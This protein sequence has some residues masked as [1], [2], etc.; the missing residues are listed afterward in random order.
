MQGLDLNQ[1]PSGYEPEA[2]IALPFPI[3]P[4]GM[5]ARNFQ[6]CLLSTGYLA[7]MLWIVLLAVLFVFH[8]PK[9]WGELVSRVGFMAGLALISPSWATGG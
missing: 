4:V 8:R 1:R 7:L 5:N 6:R 9:N 3:V 2:R